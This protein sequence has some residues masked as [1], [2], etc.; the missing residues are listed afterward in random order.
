MASKDKSQRTE[1]GG[2]A[3]VLL[4]IVLMALAGAVLGWM[5]LAPG[6]AARR[7]QMRTG[8]T[9][10][11]TTY[12]ANPLGGSLRAGEFV[13]R[14]PGAFSQ[15][16]F[17]RGRNLVASGGSGLPAATRMAGGGGGRGS[18]A[19][20]LD[21]KYVR[22]ELDTV[23]LARDADGRDNFS[24]FAAALPPVRIREFVL[25]VASMPAAPGSPDRLGQ[26]SR[27]AFAKTYR[28]LESLQPVLADLARLAL[29]DSVIP[30]PP[31]CPA[32]LPPTP[33]VQPAPPPESGPPKIE[34]RSR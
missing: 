29:T 16:V 8:F 25:V 18:D 11:L 30:P 32:L 21:Y 17:L 28:N 1:R 7:V 23:D 5:V 9:C 27:E 6:I 24:A 10:E 33:A 2:I 4:V 15:R 13:L 20:V 22:I 31:P 19:P 34:F 14:N 12:A 26:Q 3:V